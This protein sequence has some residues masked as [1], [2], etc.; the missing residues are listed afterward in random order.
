M[1]S[2]A[3]ISEFLREREAI[4]TRNPSGIRERSSL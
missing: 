2:V 3:E 1:T 4:H